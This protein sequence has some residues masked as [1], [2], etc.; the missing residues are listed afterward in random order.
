MK[1]QA[2]LFSA[3][4]YLDSSSHPKPKLDLPGVK[5]DIQAMEIRLQQIGFNIIKRENVK[6]S[7]YYSTIRE[8]TDRCP[9]DSINIVYFSGHGGHYNGNNY[10]FPSDFTTQIESTGNLEKAGININDIISIFKGKGRLVLILDSCRK[11]VGVS[12]GYYSEMTSAENVYIAYG[13]NFGDESFAERNSPS[14]FTEALCD[15]ILTSNIDVDE[16]FTNVRQNVI[17]KHKKQLPSSVNSLLEK[18]YLY[19]SFET[20]SLDKK[21]YDFVEKYGNEYN[22]K[23][24]YFMG[25]ELVFIDA[26]QYFN[27]GLLDAYWFYTKFQ[28]KTSIEKGIKMPCLSE[29]ESKIITFLNFPKHKK[30]FMFDVSHTWYYNGRQIRMGE[31]PPLPPSMQCKLPEPNKEFEVTLSAIKEENNI[32]I[33]TNLPD[34]CKLLIWH[35]DI[36]SKK[37]CF[38]SSGKIIICNARKI[39]KIVID[40]NVFTD[41]E[42]T[43]SLFGDKNRNLTGQYIKY[44]PIFGNYIYSKFIFE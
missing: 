44:N 25:E 31:I 6:K 26:A 40:S 21:V 2:F 19:S 23:H 20:D 36:I 4:E 32:V 27:I 9:I 43:K 39:N 35:N 7:D 33:H 17:T 38:V 8:Y 10:I 37:E 3:G 5:Y 34:N 1:K 18:V 12:K 11:D 41:D 16:L 24:G 15:E 30:R 42:Y 13:A 22:E 14:W 29:E 28:Y